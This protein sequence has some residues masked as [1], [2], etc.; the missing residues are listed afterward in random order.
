DNMGDEHPFYHT[1]KN[2]H[3]HKHIPHHYHRKGYS[4]G[5]LPT[6][7]SHPNHHGAFQW[8][9]DLRQ[10]IVTDIGPQPADSPIPGLRRASIEDG[11]DRDMS[12]GA[13]FV[14]GGGALPRY[15]IG[16]RR[17]CAG[18]DNRGS[19]SS[20]TCQELGL[21]QTR[22][23]LVMTTMSPAIVGPVS[24]VPIA[25][26]SY[27]DGFGQGHSHG[28]HGGFN[29]YNTLPARKLQSKSMTMPLATTAFSCR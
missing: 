23:S 15:T 7:W 10:Y 27:R 26:V 6:M 1:H 8:A 16:C 25:S 4:S 9:S 21:G 12:G 28:A 5:S 18:C 20:S 3:S 19:N 22:Q 29:G 11:Q 2:P 17:C 14:E 13:R 24:T